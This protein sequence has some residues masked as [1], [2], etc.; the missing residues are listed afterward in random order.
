MIQEIDII[1]EY[2][3]NVMTLKQGLILFARLSYQSQYIHI[4]F[5]IENCFTFY[6]LKYINY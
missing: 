1:P 5:S 6:K 4:F 2:V 3:I